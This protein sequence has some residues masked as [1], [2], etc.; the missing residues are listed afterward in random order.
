MRRLCV[1]CGSKTGNQIYA[2]A[3]LHFARLMYEHGWGLVFGGGHVGLMGVIA[4][5]MLD[6]GGEV[7]GVI[8][9]ALVERE[10]AHER[11][12]QMHI[13][14]G[15]HER[16]A[17]M[18]ELSDG[19]VALPGGYGTL[20]ELFEIVSWAQLGLHQKPIGLLNVAGFF[21]PLLEMLQRMV[22][23]GFLKEKHRR[24]LLDA[25]ESHELLVLLEK[26]HALRSD[27]RHVRSDFR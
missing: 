12:K 26:A 1:F 14:A 19:F 9:Q 24:L 17:L 8:P 11:V 16:K 5:A 21:D 22:D 13:V 23:T 15:M 27:A 6:L 7:I 3:A 4:D 25:N 10:L 20:E 18:A 2:S